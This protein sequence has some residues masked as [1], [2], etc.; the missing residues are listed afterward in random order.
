MKRFLL[1]L[2]ACAIP[3]IA[4]A[5]AWPD[6][7]LKV[8]VPFGP[9]GS[10]DLMA[11]LLQKTIEDEKL[12]PQ[13]M[14]IVNVKG[15]FSIGSQQ[16]KNAAPDGT[17]FLVLHLALLSGEVVDPSKGVSYRDYEPVAMTGGFCLH[18]IVRDDAPYKTLDDLV[19]AAKAKPKSILFGVNIGALNHLGGG[20]LE[21][22]TGAQFRFVQIGGGSANYAALKG[23]QTQTTMLSSSE[24][25]N[26]KSGGMRSLAFTGPARLDSEP[27][28]PTTK[29]L[30]LGYE[31]CINNYW[32]APKGTP[33]AAI[34]GMANALEKAMK[35][36]ALRKVQIEERASTVEFLKGDA[37]KKNLDD[38][39]KAVEP[40]AKTLVSGK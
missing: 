19:K 24:Y 1:T 11:R 31:F 15:H 36:P 16:V 9:G 21:Q 35:S 37:F 6:K 20:F 18:H 14:A 34:D 38:T 12:L 13:P 30:G 26:Y 5:Q 29:E 28:V 27:N 25:S 23:S 32:F 3:A 2:A 10:S 39:F 7:P 22:A 17:N 33:K 8:V 4:A 40:I